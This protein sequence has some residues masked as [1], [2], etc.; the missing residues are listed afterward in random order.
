MEG[1][2]TDTQSIMGRGQ[3]C[4]EWPSSCKE[5]ASTL[6][7]LRLLTVLVNQA[8]PSDMLLPKYPLKENKWNKAFI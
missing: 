4:R 5:K 3:G 6:E 7:K 1:A 8:K 2:D